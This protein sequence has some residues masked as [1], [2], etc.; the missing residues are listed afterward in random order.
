MKPIVLDIIECAAKIGLHVIAASSDIGSANR[1]LWRSFGLMTGRHS[2]TVSK[3][4][5]PQTKWLYF[6]ADVPHLIENLK[7]ALVSCKVITLP[8]DIVKAN[9]LNCSFV[10]ITPV[11]DLV[12]LR[13]IS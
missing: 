10:S 2:K 3:V 13:T 6:L 4:V 1:A 5:H 12:S 7:A 8:D 9:N 11:K